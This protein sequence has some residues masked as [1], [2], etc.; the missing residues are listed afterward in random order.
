MMLSQSRFSYN[1][2][3]AYARERNLYR[4]SR[5]ILILFVL[6]LLAIPASAQSSFLPNI[7]GGGP[8]ACKKKCDKVKKDCEKEIDRLKAACKVTGKSV[9]CNQARDNGCKASE[10]YCKAMEQVQF[11]DSKCDPPPPF[12]PDPPT[13]GGRGE[14]HYETFDGLVYDLQSAGDFPLMETTDGRFA[15]HVRMSPVYDMT[16]AQTAVGIKIDD[17]IISYDL[18]DK[19]WTVTDGERSIPWAEAVSGPVNGIIMGERSHGRFIIMKP[20]IGLVQVH[21]LTGHLN[22]DVHLLSEQTTRGLL[23]NQNGAALDD[24]SIPDGADLWAWLHTEYAQVMRFTES[25]PLLPYREGETARTFAVSGHPGRKAKATMAALE[26]A[27]ARCEAEGL[28]EPWFAICVHDIAVTGDESYSAGL[29]RREK[30]DLVYA[31]S[32]N[33]SVFEEIRTWLRAGD[34]PSFTHA[35]DLVRPVETEPDTDENA[36]YGFVPVDLTG[37]SES[38]IGGSG[39]GNWF[40][41]DSANAARVD[42][43]IRYPVFLQS[44]PIQ[45]AYRFKTSIKVE[46][47][48]KDHLGFILGLQSIGDAGEDVDFLLLD[49]KHSDARYRGVPAPE[50][51]RL[52][53]FKGTLPKTLDRTSLVERFWGHADPALIT[54]LATETGPETGWQFGRTYEVEIAYSNS[55]ISLIV[56][57]ENVLRHQGAFPTVSAM[58]L[59]SYSQSNLE[60]SQVRLQQD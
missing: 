52:S 7:F 2:S 11:G 30:P 36:N 45:G 57:G 6:A 37:W 27:R 38:A 5:F 28:V 40:I 54:P 10:Q 19:T 39:D 16:S 47:P 42:N 12:E 51:W 17:T 56:D 43:N 48:Q 35:S 32:G 50:G 53:A 22:V 46:A 9:F 20:D 60:F 49:W 15:V 25:S 59:Y 26:S 14:P 3:I 1:H 31:S 44:E 29:D 58:G 8:E 34:V 4:T 18:R 41:A 23:G 24:L 13:G 33:P 21:V 55:E